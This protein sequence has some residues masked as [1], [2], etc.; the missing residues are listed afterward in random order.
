MEPHFSVYSHSQ[1]SLQYFKPQQCVYGLSY[2]N[3][4]NAFFLVQPKVFRV[5][6]TSIW[7]I[8]Q[9]GFHSTLNNARLGSSIIFFLKRNERIEVSYNFNCCDF[10]ENIVRS[11]LQDL[12]LTLSLITL[13]VNAFNRD[14]QLRL[15]SRSFTNIKTILFHSI[16]TINFATHDHSWHEVEFWFFKD[17]DSKNW[18]LLIPFFATIILET[19]CTKYAELFFAS[20]CRPDGSS[21]YIWRKQ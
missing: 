9:V 11:I 12:P 7:Y 20:T 3:Y 15:F 5:K 8:I 6:K 19:N 18:K 14:S 13:K 16:I 17:W 2:P 10:T 21:T 1:W 4:A